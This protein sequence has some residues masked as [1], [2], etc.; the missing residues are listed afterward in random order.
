L[1]I[2]EHYTLAVHLAHE[3][4]SSRWRMR[5]A[6]ARTAVGTVQVNAPSGRQRHALSDAIIRCHLVA[7]QSNAAISRSQQLDDRDRR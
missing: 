2:E 5:T 3:L 4:H 6:F 7:A 1:R